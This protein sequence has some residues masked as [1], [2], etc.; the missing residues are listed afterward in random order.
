MLLPG[1]TV[2][3]AAETV[4]LKEIIIKNILTIIIYKYFLFIL[5]PQIPFR[6][7]TI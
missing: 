3:L 1:L 6:R 4:P 2:K 5:T 7:T